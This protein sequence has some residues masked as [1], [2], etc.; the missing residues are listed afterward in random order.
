MTTPGRPRF[1]K[2]CRSRFT[3]AGRPV[4]RRVPT[5]VLKVRDDL[6]GSHDGAGGH[7]PRISHSP[8]TMSTSASVSILG[9]TESFENIP[10]SI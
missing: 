6:P 4:A 3:L 9:R 1:R 8:R 10:S 7:D 5:A 2:S